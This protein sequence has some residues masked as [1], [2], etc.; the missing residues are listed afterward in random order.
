MTSFFDVNN[1]SNDKV[2]FR[3]TASATIDCVGS[4]SANYTAMTFTR[5]GDT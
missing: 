1:T 5:L 4:T 3:V 2:R